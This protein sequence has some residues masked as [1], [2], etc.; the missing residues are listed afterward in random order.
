MPPIKIYDNID[1]F[2]TPSSFMKGKI[3]QAGIPQEKVRNLFYTIQ[4]KEYPYSPAFE[5]YFIYFG[6]LSWEKGIF[7]LLKAMQDVHQSKLL[8]IG[9]GP[10]RKELEIF[11]VDNDL[12]NV[13]FLGSK[14]GNE[15]KSL[16]SKAKFV[17]VP[18][19]WY[20]NSPLV[21]YESFSMGKP[22]I[23]ASIGGISELID[24][25]EN[26]LLFDAGD[27]EG[28]KEHILSLLNN[29]QKVTQFSENARE[30]AELHFS[31]DRHYEKIT[32]LYRQTISV[33]S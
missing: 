32:D 21:I 1:M 23:G 8:I 12:K 14:N 6:R 31:P 33:T 20:E 26:G 18:S 22:V 10:V 29:P 4:I 25:E 7:T 11:A 16:V 30:K 3:L 9:D 17:I 19:E 24:H 13:V 28:L 15:L 5:D 27:A 2:H